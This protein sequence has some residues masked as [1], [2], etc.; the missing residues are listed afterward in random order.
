MIYSNHTLF[1]H[2]RYNK[3]H[4]IPLKDIRVEEIPDNETLVSPDYNDDGDILRNGW[5]IISPTKSF[6]VYAQTANEKQEWM[7]HMKRGIEEQ[8]MKAGKFYVCPV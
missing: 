1:Y 7:S 4:I 5:L 6:A 8:R 2:F 3:Q